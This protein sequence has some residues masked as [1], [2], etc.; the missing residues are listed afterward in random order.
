MRKR[1]GIYGASP[2]ALQLVPMLEDN[3]EVEIAVVFD[4]D[5]D[6]ARARLRGLEPVLAETVAEVLTDDPTALG[7]TARLHAV[8]DSGL[9]P[10]FA[11]FNRDASQPNLQIVSPLTARLLWGYGASGRDHKSELLNALQEVVE[12]YNLTVD[13]D[14]LFARMLE[15][16]LGVTGADRGSLMLL[17]PQGRELRIRVAV[18]I[19]RELWPKIRVPLGEG[20]AGRAAQ[21]RRP[22]HV[23]GKADREAFQIVRERLDVESA[24]CVPLIHADQLLGVLNLHHST[25]PEAFGESD[26]QFVEQLAILDAQIIARSQEHE[27]LRQQAARYTAVREVRNILAGKALLLDRLTELC[28][29]V[30]E[31]AGQGIATLYLHDPDDAELRL[32]ATSLAGGGLGGE[33]RIA[34]GQGIDGAAAFDRRPAFLRKADGSLAVASLPLTCAERLVGVLSVQTGTSSSKNPI[35]EETLREIACAL[36]EEIDQAEHEAQMSASATKANAINEMGIRLVSATDVAE[37]VRLATSSGSMILEADHAILRL[38][39]P[40]SGR[41]VI[42]S[43]YGSADGRLQEKLF[44]LDKRIAVDVI[45]RRSPRLVQAVAQD[46]DLR[47][48][49]TGVRSLMASP[50][51]REGRV[52]GT[53]TFYDKIAADSFY[54][55]TFHDADFQVFAKFVTYVERAVEHAAF[56]TQARRHRSLDEET[57]LPNATYLATR[58][59][60]EI[61]RA[62]DR[63][64]AFALMSCRI[65]NHEAILEAADP[66]HLQRVI[67]ASAEALK[68][69]LRSFD[70][71]AR[72]G[73]AE[74]MVLLPDPGA[75]PGE[76]IATLARRVAEEVTKDDALNEPRRV[77]LAFGYAIHPADG[78]ADGRAG[79][80]SSG[81]DRLIAAAAAPRIRMV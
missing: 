6:A 14:E 24:L 34:L 23:R 47:A 54:A 41:Y 3:A 33:Y 53:L 35:L 65:E 44:R 67:R 22:Y 81:R 58:I 79:E 40:G 75:T 27:N 55:G 46:A 15:I 10:S 1:I 66:G 21:D 5:L 48:F 29:F 26:L 13:A 50:L 49:E 39:D 38:Q 76:W 57:S 19:E 74:F 9:E 56:H 45:K 62:G 2:D 12:S 68:T 60:E 32:A 80:D 64:G 4:P 69:H 78:R 17:D 37:V 7:P 72:T 11:R 30:A 59:D 42:R 73:V 28:R 31:S 61:A 36:A 63:A 52:I 71:P 20:I 70:V 16:A 77:E 43:Y 51:R 8:I 25:R 18:G